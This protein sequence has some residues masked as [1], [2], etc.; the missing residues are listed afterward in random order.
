MNKGKPSEER[1]K[2]TTTALNHSMPVQRSIKKLRLK[3]S[4]EGRKYVSGTMEDVQKLR[5]HILLGSIE[6]TTTRRVAFKK[7]T[8]SGAAN[9][10][11]VMNKPVSD[12]VETAFGNVCDWVLK[13]T[14]MLVNSDNEDWEEVDVDDIV[15]NVAPAQQAPQSMIRSTQ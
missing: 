3:K 14:V 5:S 12:R 11:F 13:N 7:T 10:D 9:A 2:V 15:V 8:W 6:N 4:Q 1:I